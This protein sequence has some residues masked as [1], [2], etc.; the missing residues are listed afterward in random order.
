MHPSEYLP[1][2]DITVLVCC[3]IDW[4]EF[5]RTV[6]PAKRLKDGF[7]CPV[8]KHVMGRVRDSLRQAAADGSGSSNMDKVAFSAVSAAC[9]TL[10]SPE[11]VEECRKAFSDRGER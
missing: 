9:A 4:I 11:L 5:V 1:S 10:P 2:S 3:D 7:G 8:C 6:Q